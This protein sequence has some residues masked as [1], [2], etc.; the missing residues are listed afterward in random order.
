MF[1]IMKKYIFYSSYD[2]VLNSAYDSQAANIPKVDSFRDMFKFFGGNITLLDRTDSI[3]LPMKAHLLDNMR[4]PAF[5]KFDKSFEQLC[6]ERAI[7]LYNQAKNSNRKIV[8][9]YSG[10]IDSTSILCSF[11][12][13]RTEKELK[14]D[15]IVLMSNLSVGENRNFADK[16]V[17]K[18]FN[19]DNSYKH[20][21]YLG[22]DEFLFVTGENADQLFGSQVNDNFGFWS[23][24]YN[25]LFEPYENC[26]PELKTWI[27]SILDNDMD[28]TERLLY[29]LERIVSKSS[30]EIPDTYSFFWWLNFATK[31]QSVYVRILA[32]SRNMDT[33]K[34]EEN[35]TTFF[36]TQ[37]FQL[38]SMNNVESFNKFK[39]QTSVK[40]PAKEY[41]YTVTKDD[42]YMNK[43]KVGSLWRLAVQKAVPFGLYL[44]GQTIRKENQYISKEHYNFNSDI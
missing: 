17:F 42:Q 12:R 14:E 23:G 36:G 28:R 40:Y 10:G 19:I 20:P 44:D 35:Y 22:R 3:E 37:E 13:T 24:K 15:F 9:M 11:L 30:V 41:I 25:Q 29:N 26:K 2:L 8:V 39:T 27:A 34:L 18:Y 4:M 21:Y 5:Q 16:F 6:D 31:W 7:E 1:M 33:I 43:I 32:Y 38:W